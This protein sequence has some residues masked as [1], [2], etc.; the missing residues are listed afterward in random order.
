MDGIN[1]AAHLSLSVGVVVTILFS[2]P[3]FLMEFTI[4]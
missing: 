3:I 4:P 2:L 1:T